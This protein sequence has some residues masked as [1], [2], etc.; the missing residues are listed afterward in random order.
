MPPEEEEK[1][2]C[3]LGFSLGTPRG[4]LH[5]HSLALGF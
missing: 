3:A 4:A 1:V 5:H 2:Q